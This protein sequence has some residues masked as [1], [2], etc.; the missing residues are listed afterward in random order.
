MVS[1]DI[2]GMIIRSC[3]PLNTAT[4]TRKDEDKDK[5]KKRVGENKRECGTWWSIYTVIHLLQSSHQVPFIDDTNTDIL[6]EKDAPTV[7]DVH[8]HPHNFIYAQV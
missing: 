6:N 1:V 5:D 7:A 2:S 8:L 3:V 4:L